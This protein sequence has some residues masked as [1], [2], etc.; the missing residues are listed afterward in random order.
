MD[1]ILNMWKD[2]LAEDINKLLKEKEL[3]A[4]ILAEALIDLREA[5]EE[6]L[7]DTQ[8]R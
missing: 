7:N 6:Y 3:W 4:A 1:K 8:S 5:I 2:K